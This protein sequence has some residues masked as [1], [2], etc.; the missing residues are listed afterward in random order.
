MGSLYL[1]AYIPKLKDAKIH[2]LKLYHKRAGSVI[3]ILISFV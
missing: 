2:S 1:P 3:A